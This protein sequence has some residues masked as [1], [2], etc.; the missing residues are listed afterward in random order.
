MASSQVEQKSLLI[1][2][3]MKQ[4][5]WIHESEKWLLRHGHGLGRGGVFW[6]VREILYV[7]KNAKKLGG[8]FFKIFS[9]LCGEV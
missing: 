1:T 2:K 8:I 5:N 9:P 4:K 3:I 7:T 6:S